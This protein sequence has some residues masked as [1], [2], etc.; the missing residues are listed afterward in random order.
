ML[1]IRRMPLESNLHAKVSGMDKIRIRLLIII[2]SCAINIATI[3]EII[4]I[5]IMFYRSLLSEKN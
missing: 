5:F 4:N 1:R 3:I 2:I